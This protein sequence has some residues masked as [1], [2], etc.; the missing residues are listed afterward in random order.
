MNKRGY[1]S[2][3]GFNITSG[4]EGLKDKAVAG[5]PSVTRL[6]QSSCIEENPS[7]I[8]IIDE[9]NMLITSPILDEII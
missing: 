4:S 2:L 1:V 3:G 8:P 9:R 5:N 7:G 6:T